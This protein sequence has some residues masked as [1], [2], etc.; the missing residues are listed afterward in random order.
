MCACSS[1]RVLMSIGCPTRTTPSGPAA[2]EQGIGSAELSRGRASLI[3]RSVAGA[4][5]RLKPLVEATSRPVDARVRI[6][7]LLPGYWLEHLSPTTGVRHVGMAPGRPTRLPQKW[8]PALARM[9]HLCVPSAHNRGGAARRA[10]APSGRNS[11]PASLSRDAAAAAAR[12]PR[13]AREIPRHPVRTTPCSTRSTPGPRAN[14]LRR[15][16]TASCAASA[17]GPRRAHRQD[18]PRSPVR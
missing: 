6:I 2:S 11:G 7:H 1:K 16:S 8:L 10:G 12:A 9:D 17:G 3:A 15:S 13:R 14:A 18:Q 5:S 4:D